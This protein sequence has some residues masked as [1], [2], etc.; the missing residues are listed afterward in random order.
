[1]KIKEIPTAMTFMMSNTSGPLSGGTIIKEGAT[2][3]GNTVFS[4]PMRQMVLK[5]SLSKQG[6]AP[7]CQ[8]SLEAN[9]RQSI[10]N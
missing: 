3:E 6:I 5:S 10:E 4:I 8:P 1:M 9:M 7:F 2:F